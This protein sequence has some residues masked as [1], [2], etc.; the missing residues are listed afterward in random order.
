M[1][2]TRTD[3]QIARETIFG[4]PPQGQPQETVETPENATPPTGDPQPPEPEPAETPAPAEPDFTNIPDDRLLGLLNTKFNV[5]FDTLEQA[6]D[7]ISNQ[8]QFRGQEEII[9]QLAEKLKEKSNVLSHFPSENAYKVAYLAKEK[10]PQKEGVLT[11]IINSDVDNLP[12]LEAI[13]L[14]EA[15]NRPNGSKVNPLR[16]KLSLLG[17]KDLDV[18][19]FDDWDE[20]DKEIVYGAAEDARIALKGVQA[21]VTVPKEGDPEITEMI[22]Q[23]ERGVLEGKEKTEKLIQVISPI[24]ET[25][26]KGLSKIKPVDG[27]D[28]EYT[29][30][31]DQ[32]SQK[33]LQEFVLAEAIEG[34]YNLQSDS[35]IRTLNNMLVS[36][37]WATDGPK[38]LAA[39][40]KYKEDKVW[41]QARRKYENAEPLN[42]QTPPSAG[43]KTV[44]TD[45]DRARRLLGF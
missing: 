9:S 23:I 7:F 45:N 36:E 11:S 4:V 5:K 16:Y 33:S 28:F 8:K 6:N 30:S 1:E 3:E 20:A 37:I 19:E 17:L 15:L 27:E 35:D 34:Q 29:V 38:I 40:G 44:E 31:L 25:M 26:V 21:S 14:A 42:Q 2:D 18:A 41:E 13:S 10:Y 39:F 32:E 22:S 24:A 12:D 43:E